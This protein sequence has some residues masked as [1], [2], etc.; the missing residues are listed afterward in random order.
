MRVK[1]AAVIQ[2][3][4]GSTRYPGKVLRPLAG[5]P[6]LEHIIKRAQAQKNL[7]RI[8]LA[9]PDAPSE[10]RLRE[11]GA[12]CGIGVVKGPEEDVLRRFIIAGQSVNAEHI[13]RICADSPLI[14]PLLGD[15][16]TTGHLQA[17]A[18]YT[19]VADTVPLG[20]SMEVVRAAVLERIADITTKKPYREHVT[21][22]I[23]DHPGRYRIHRVPAPPYLR[24][25][26]FRLTVD[27]DKD[28]L[29]MDKLYNLFCLPPGRLVDL[30]QA[31][32]HLE[33]HPETALL[34]ADVKQK[35]WRLEK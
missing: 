26:T 31:I 9:V 29:V 28:F 13:V 25:K 32:R 16:L 15:A 22:Y 8:I 10:D 34:N 35:N 5:L 27:T 6:M 17:D 4:T 2:A 14:D 3:R 23:V 33:T 1:I 21:S 18:D 7:D 30:E 12:K 19:I 20:T 24:G 11:L